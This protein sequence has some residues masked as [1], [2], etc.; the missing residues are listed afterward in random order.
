[1]GKTGNA[2]LQNGHGGDQL[3]MLT[4][5]M[6]LEGTNRKRPPAKWPW[7]GPTGNA[8]LQNGHG[9]DQP[10]TL[11]CKMA[12]EGTNR[13]RSPAQWP[14]RGPTG[15][16][17]LQTVDRVVKAEVHGPVSQLFSDGDAGVALETPVPMVGHGHVDVT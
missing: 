12:T 5:K 11:T 13:K 10:E 4:C 7:R 17:H 2:H 1:M 6:A 14:R 9:G 8:H 16:A 3:E 15:N